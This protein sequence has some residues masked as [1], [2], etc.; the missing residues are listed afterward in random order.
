MLPKTRFGML[1]KVM[2]AAKKN[3]ASE[4][5][6]ASSDKIPA[7]KLPLGTFRETLKTT[8]SVSFSSASAAPSSS[9][10]NAGVPQEPVSKVIGEMFLGNKL[11]AVD[12]ARLARG[13][14][15]SEAKGVSEMAAIGANG[16]HPKN[17]ARDLMH[18]LLKDCPAAN[19][20]WYSVRVWNP[21]QQITETVKL[22]F[23]LPHRQ[24]AAMGAAVDS[25]LLQTGMSPE[26]RKVF[27]A[28]CAKLG[29]NP[30]TTI[31]L[32]LHG[33]GV[34]F[35]KK[36][37]IELLSYNFL[38][39]PM[40]DRIPF[41]G[42]SKMYI[43]KCGCLGKHTWDD[44]LEVFVWSL[45]ALLVGTHPS[46]GPRNEPLADRY[47]ANDAGKPL[48]CPQAIL[49]QVRADWPFLKTLFSIP[50]WQNNAICWR[51]GAD[52]NTNSYKD[53]SGNANWRRLRKG[54]AELFEELKEKVASLSPLF[55][56]P[57][58]EVAMI[59]LDW[60]H[61]VD[62]G[63]AQDLIGNLFAELIRKCLPGNNKGERLKCL[64]TKLRTFYKES[65]T[66]CRLD[67]LTEEMFQRSGKSPKLKAKGG[68]TR[69]LIPF[70]AVLS[71][72][73]AG[74]ENT[75]HWRAVAAIFDRLLDC[76][77]Q[78][79]KTPFEPEALSKSCRELCILWSV[80]EQEAT[81]EGKVAWVKKPKVH[82]FQE[83][84]EYQVHSLGSPEFF[85]T[86]RDESWCG[87]MS[88]AAKRRGGQKFASTVPERLLNRFRAMQKPGQQIKL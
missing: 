48:G 22:P 68:E 47:L 36:D 78:A 16:C 9:S 39:E 10:S 17:F 6:P 73:I 40:G 4:S 64:W 82:L 49:C 30:S 77:K 46:V 56:A 83:L 15:T 69:Q 54:A 65:K 51:C 55:S 74:Q 26:M 85:W 61:I 41:A 20:F 75:P 57:G 43:C 31:S 84:C 1:R 72:E 29:L 18:Q 24:L 3:S 13:A 80:L 59:I 27:S 11:S 33:D 19:L 14:R 2:A 35:T 87:H 44:I 34:P 21:A 70:A 52:K 38:G 86:Y 25:K 28:A 5:A 58:F 88:T 67:N 71:A 60:L 53:S 8:K 62:L 63:I 37:S 45:R 23:L 32:G 50:T 76:C 81:A 12:C 66:P 42:I 7:I 79:A